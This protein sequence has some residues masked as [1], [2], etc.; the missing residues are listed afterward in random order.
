MPVCISG[1]T[2]VTAKLIT[3]EGDQYMEE[4]PIS[5]PGLRFLST[6]PCEVISGIDIFKIFCYTVS[7]K[8]MKRNLC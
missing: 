4:R 1:Q 5:C 6:F 2:L 7:V 8:L 3:L